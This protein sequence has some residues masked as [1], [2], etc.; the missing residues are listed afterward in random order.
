MF[1]HASLSTSVKREAMFKKLLV[2]LGVGYLPYAD[3]S[4]V[5]DGREG[6]AGG[7]YSALSSCWFIIDGE[8]NGTQG[9]VIGCRE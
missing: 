7:H 5:E 3:A 9:G 1:S 4:E 6:T 2:L 8:L